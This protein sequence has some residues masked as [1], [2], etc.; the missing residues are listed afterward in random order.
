MILY[1]DL[2]GCFLDIDT[3]SFNDT[4][5][6]A[7]KF[8]DS[9]NILIFCSS[10]T[11]D[12]ID[13]IMIKIDRQMPYIVENGGGIYIPNKFKFW[14]DYSKIANV[15]GDLF[16]VSKYNS[17]IYKTIKYIREEIGVEMYTYQDLNINQICSITGLNKYQAA[18]AKNRKFSETI[19]TPLNNQKISILESRLK[20]INL[21]CTKGSRFYTIHPNDINK[22]KAALMLFQKIQNMKIGNNLTIGIGDSYNDESLLDFTNKSY[23][24]KNKHN[25]WSNI[26]GDNIIRIDG[27]GQDGWIKV[28]KEITKSFK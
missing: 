12:E 22:G 7:R 2:D 21:T 6:Y 13:S 10:K 27:T 19:I 8:I 17:N 16:Q 23:L 14:E 1:S 11:Y 26:K 25:E 24:L 18:L 4:I 20:K 3:Y 28:Y 15:D 5:K 9:G